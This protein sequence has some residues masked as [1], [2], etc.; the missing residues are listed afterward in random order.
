MALHGKHSIAREWI[1][2]STDVLAA[3]VYPAAIIVVV[4]LVMWKFPVPG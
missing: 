4:V 2:W 1:G 3:L